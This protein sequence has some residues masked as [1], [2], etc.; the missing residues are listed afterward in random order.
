MHR[1]SEKQ[2]LISSLDP[3]SS[4]C[5]LQHITLF[6][7]QT[8]LFEILKY[9]SNFDSFIKENLETVVQQ[10]GTHSVMASPPEIAHALKDQENKALERLWKD[11]DIN[12]GIRDCQKRAGFD[13]EMHRAKLAK[14]KQE[15]L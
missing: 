11:R 2:N 12:T 10:D 8:L 15:S 6:W 3:I 14:Q 9:G 13:E 5:I 1:T 4:F 7:N